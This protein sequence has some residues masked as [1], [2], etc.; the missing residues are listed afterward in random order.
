MDVERRFKK[1]QRFNKRKNAKFLALIT[2]E[3]RMLLF[4]EAKL[5]REVRREFVWAKR[6]AGFEKKNRLL[7][8]IERIVVELHVIKE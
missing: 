2:S 7:L 8:I 6:K 4:F 1:R 3:K 5:A